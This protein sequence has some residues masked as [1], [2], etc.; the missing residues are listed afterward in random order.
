M[1]CV[2]HLVLKIVKPSS[3]APKCLCTECELGQNFVRSPPF[4]KPGRLFYSPT[5]IPCT[6]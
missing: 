6:V 3:E 2:S 1:N 5:Y 4:L